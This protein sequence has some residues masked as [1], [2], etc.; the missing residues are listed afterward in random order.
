MKSQILFTIKIKKMKKLIL[1]AKNGIT[2]QDKDDGFVLKNMTV[3]NFKENGVLLAHVDNFLLS[4]V[5]T[6]NVGAYGL[7]PV[8]CKTGC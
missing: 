8:F 5:A 6:I 1:Y 7:F 2:V 4:H 3:Q